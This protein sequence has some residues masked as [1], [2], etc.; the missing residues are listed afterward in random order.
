ML[1]EKI[2]EFNIP[3]LEG[4]DL[5]CDQLVPNKCV[6]LSCT[7]CALSSYASEEVRLTAAIIMM[8]HRIIKIR[9][10]ETNANV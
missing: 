8:S 5:R 1:K 7:R 9:E 10:E 3:D 2:G 6:G 4:K